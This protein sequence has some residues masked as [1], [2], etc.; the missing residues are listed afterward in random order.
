MTAERAKVSGH[1]R[2]AIS[3]RLTERIAT[4]A[5]RV[6]VKPKVDEVIFPWDYFIQ[7]LESS[8]HQESRDQPSSTVAPAV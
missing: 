1:E 7:I 6:K 8:R 3:G 5:A 4:V 2:G